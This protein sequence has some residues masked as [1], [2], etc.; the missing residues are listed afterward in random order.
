MLLDPTYA[1][2]EG[3]LAFAAPGCHVVRL[4][5]MDPAT[6]AY[7]PASEP[8]AVIACVGGGSNAMGIFHAFLPD[9]SVALV[10]CEAGGDGIET[11]RHAA[12][13]TAGTLCPSA[14]S[15][16]GPCHPAA[17]G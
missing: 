4:R 6:W 9:A 2:Y 16:V 15:T 17:A 13:L 8:D 7:R 11:G 10:G 5:V 12:P 1:N 14:C 3:Q